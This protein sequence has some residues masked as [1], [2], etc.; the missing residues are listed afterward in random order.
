MHSGNIHVVGG[1]RVIPPFRAAGA[2]LHPA[3]DA[4]AV[5]AA[6]REIAGRG[7]GSLV[8]VTEAAAA[9]APEAV[10]EMEERGRHAVMR[11]PTRIG[12]GSGG[13]ERMRGIIIRSV[14][15]D[16]LSRAPAGEIPEEIVH[17]EGEESGG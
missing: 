3:D 11:V 12:G 10:A 6:L 13:L 17:G 1:S 9:L 2:L 14:G 5:E 4:A 7:R 16:L 8:L 15:V